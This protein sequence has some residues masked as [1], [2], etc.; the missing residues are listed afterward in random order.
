MRLCI[1][2][3]GGAPGVLVLAAM[4]MAPALD[5]QDPPTF[6]AWVALYAPD[7]I[8][9]LENENRLGELCPD[10]STLD[11]CYANHLA[12]AVVVRTLY[13]GP[14]TT[15]R[16]VG[17]LLVLASPGRGLS[18]HF[19]AAGAAAVAPF[20]PDLVLRDWGYGPYFHQTFVAQRGP[21]FGLPAGPWAE[22]VWLLGDE[23]RDDPAVMSVRAGDIIELAGS[24]WLVVA[25]ESDALVLRAEQ[26][27]DMWC[28]EGTPPPVVPTAVTRRSRRELSDGAGH[29]VFRPRY[30]KGC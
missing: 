27:A 23:G 13:A 28:E 25:A 24:G 12:P 3:R 10:P 14:D 29:L 21:W 9:W 17:D 7:Q 6:R 20:T 30:L 26:P 4:A 19:R 16:V 8:A 18:A 15:A 1:P 2:C 11:A 5:A 22:P